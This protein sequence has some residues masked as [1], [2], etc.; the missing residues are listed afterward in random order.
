MNSSQEVAD[1]PHS[2]I[3]PRSMSKKIASSGLANLREITGKRKRR[4]QRYAREHKERQKLA[5]RDREV[6]EAQH[7]DSSKTGSSRGERGRELRVGYAGEGV[8]SIMRTGLIA[9]GVIARKQIAGEV[10]QPL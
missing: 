2:D 5:P 4:Q 6:H 3:P 8:G 1:F 10:Q 9:A 7:G